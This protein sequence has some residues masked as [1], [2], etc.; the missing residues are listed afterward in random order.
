MS[1]IPKMPSQMQVLSGV[2][3]GKEEKRNKDWKNPLHFGIL[4][5]MH[6]ILNHIEQKADLLHFKNISQ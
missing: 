2:D 1:G 3:G 5:R 4:G 6:Y